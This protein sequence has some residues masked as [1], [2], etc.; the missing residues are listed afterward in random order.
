M[1][2]I[3][4]FV[5]YIHTPT[6]EKIKTFPSKQGKIRRYFPKISLKRRKNE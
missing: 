5:L 4:G 1:L 2:I 3:G 6:L